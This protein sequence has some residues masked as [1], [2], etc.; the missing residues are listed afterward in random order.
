MPESVLLA[1]PTFR[2][3][4]ML[5]RLLDTVPE[6]VEGAQVTVRLLV[7]DNDCDSTIAD[8]VRAHKT[9]E[10]LHVDYVAVPQAGIPA[11]R[12][13]ALRAARAHDYLAFVDDDE[14]LAPGWLLSHLTALA[15][16]DADVVAGPVLP[17][18]ADGRPR[19]LADLSPYRFAEPR[20]PLGARLPWCATNN[21]LVRT[22]SLRD[23]GFDE[24]Y[25][26]SGGSD[27]HFFFRLARSGARIVWNPEARAIALV[28]RD[29][30]TL[31]WLLRRAFRGGAIR[32]KMRMEVL[33]PGPWIA[34]QVT[35]AAGSLVLGLT[36]LVIGLFRW[37]APIALRGSQRLFS[38]VG[39]FAGFFG[40]AG[41]EY[42]DLLRR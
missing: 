16:F 32:T 34:A 13:V 26:A 33:G 8:L 20:L 1:I 36:L 17:R 22:R 19:W 39:A 24:R 37:S 3:A 12:N 31:S 9:G 15:R 30:M 29:R 28:P 14:E 40:V 38:G 42:R 10:R 7:L 41:H 21:T 5:S 11:V 25:S 4:Q 23:F 6:A 35:K 27:S 2:R 18:A